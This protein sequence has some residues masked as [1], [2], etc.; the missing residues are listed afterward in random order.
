[1][2]GYYPPRFIFSRQPG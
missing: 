1:M 2:C